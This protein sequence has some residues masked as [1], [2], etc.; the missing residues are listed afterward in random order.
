MNTY[1]KKNPEKFNQEIKNKIFL[2]SYMYE[3]YEKQI[4]SKIISYIEKNIKSHKENNLQ[5]KKIIKLLFLKNQSEINSISKKRLLKNNF[6]NHEDKVN[7]LGY[8]KSLLK[9]SEKIK[10]EKIQEIL[11]LEKEIFLKK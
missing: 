10:I 8:I 6:D 2:L 3:A 1:N 7:L 4:D 9:R 11:G 5:L